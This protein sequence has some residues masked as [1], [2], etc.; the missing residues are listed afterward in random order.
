MSFK[1][2]FDLTFEQNGVTDGG[3]NKKSTGSIRSNCNNSKNE[4]GSDCSKIRK[5]DGKKEQGKNHDSNEKEKGK[6]PLSI[7]D[8]DVLLKNRPSC[9]PQKEWKSS[10][11]H[12]ETNGHNSGDGDGGTVGKIT[13]HRILHTEQPFKAS[14]SNSCNRTK[15]QNNNL[16]NT[17]DDDDD[18]KIGISIMAQKNNTDI[19][20]GKYEG[21]LKV[22]E[23]SIDLCN[24]LQEHIQFINQQQHSQTR[25]QQKQD[26][27]STSPILNIGSKEAM[28]NV[29][30]IAI[31]KAM[32]KGGRTIELG[33]GHGLPGCLILKEIMSNH[34]SMTCIKTNLSRN[35]AMEVST[36]TPNP[37]PFVLFTDYN[38]FVV[39][40]V[41]LPN[42]IL[43]CVSLAHHSDDNDDNVYDS[44]HSMTG[45]VA[46][47]WME[48]SKQLK[49]KTHDSTT[50]SSPSLLE[51][52][53]FS[54][55]NVAETSEDS[56]VPTTSASTSNVRFDLILASET[57]YTISSSEDTARWLFN[58]LKYDTGIGLVSM[59]RYYFGVGGS[60]DTFREMAQKSFG[61]TVEL[62]REYKDGTSNIRDLLRVRLLRGDKNSTKNSR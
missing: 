55:L 20:P 36:A 25:E 3:D 2:D 57:T 41:T 13:M 44:L 12:F 17:Y 50:S 22:W 9:N 24:Y 45:L 27:I 49:L 60:T 52:E 31:Q 21:G 4:E 46:G 51:Q 56:K 29:D 1:F 37:A 5:Q 33:C 53:P 48:L 26:K 8:I 30:T 39:R 7:I 28:P 10:E 32:S 42:I 38:S 54:I 62:V 18:D 14:T 47:D 61:L 16:T 40:D 15:T 58:H 23:C 19:I 6:M 35:E 43:N 11:I 59:K 34:H